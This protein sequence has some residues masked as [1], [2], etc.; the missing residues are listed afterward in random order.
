MTEPPFEIDRIGALVVQALNAV[1]AAGEDL[2]VELPSRQIAAAAAVP[3]DCAQVVAYVTRLG[4]GAPESRSGAGTYPTADASD[5]LYSATLVIGIV[6]GSHTVMKGGTSASPPGP[7]AYLEN[8]TSASGDAAVLL[9][10]AD[11]IQNG[12][13]GLATGAVPRAVTFTAPQGGLV[14]TTCQVTELA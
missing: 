3:Y 2:S 1:V 14:A 6:R 5:T 4:T 7:A 8:L 9:R 13:W 10:A 12:T 11:R